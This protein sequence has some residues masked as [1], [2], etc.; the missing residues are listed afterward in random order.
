M[1]LVICNKH[2]EQGFFEVCEHL[3]NDLNKGVYPEMKELSL[4]RVKVCEDCYNKYEI[5]KLPLVS[6]SDV[7]NDPDAVSDEDFELAHNK[8]KQIKRFVFC[9]I[10]AME[11]QL[12]WARKQGKKDPFDAYENTITFK[13]KNIA[14]ELKKY[15]LE[16]FEF[17]QSIINPG[18]EALFIYPGHIGEPLLIKIYYVVVS[19]EQNMLIKLI[20]EFFQK[21]DKKQ[22]KI[23]FYE[24]E[25]WIKGKTDAGYITHHRGEEKILKEIFIK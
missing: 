24:S 9:R 4:L 21:Q 19:N 10:C 12:Q 6:L 13:E 11:I 8:Y 3:Y 1:G 22:R 2:G 14:G 25:S 23:L 18:S 17:Q 20:D 15:L 16:N 7:L 5:N